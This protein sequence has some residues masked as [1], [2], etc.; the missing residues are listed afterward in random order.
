MEAMASVQ[1]TR[2]TYSDLVASVP[3]DGKRYELI[4]GE[5]YVSPSPREKH[6]RAVRNLLVLLTEAARRGRRGRVYAA[7]F[8]TVFD[9]DNAVQPDILFVARGREGI[10]DEIVRGA[11]DLVVEVLSDSSRDR[12]RTLKL[13][14]YEQFGVTEYWV[15]DAAAEAVEIYRRSEAGTAY[16]LAGRLTAGDRLTTTPIPELDITVAQIFELD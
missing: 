4:D 9:A 8:D 5:V 13:R 3:E 16:T 2:L 6:Q 7:P 1:R 15:I 12:D 14:L 11:P 10:I